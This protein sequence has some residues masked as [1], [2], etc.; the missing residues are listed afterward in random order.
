MV[1]VGVIPD[2]EKDGMGS[3]PQGICFVVTP[4]GG[5]G[6]R[7]RTKPVR[8]R[9]TMSFPTTRIIQIRAGVPCFN[10]KCVT[11]ASEPESPANTDGFKLF[12]PYAIRS[13]MRFRVAARNDKVV[14]APHPSPPRVGEGI[15]QTPFPS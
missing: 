1:T 10:R 13:T 14:I 4:V 7:Q 3:I 5:D 2:L 11:P 8:W 15:L 9:K 6:E 12:R